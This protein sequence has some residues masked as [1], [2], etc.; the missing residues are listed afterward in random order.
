MSDSWEVTTI[1]QTRVS[2]ALNDGGCRRLRESVGS[3]L[4]VFRVSSVSGIVRF[5]GIGGAA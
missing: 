1:E 5:G 2:A 4:S 3:E